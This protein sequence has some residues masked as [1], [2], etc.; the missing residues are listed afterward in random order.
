MGLARC[1]T[2][3][4]VSMEGGGVGGGCAGGGVP[5]G[6]VP[7]MFWCGEVSLEAKQMSLYMIL[8]VTTLYGV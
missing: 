7:A 4:P 1:G 3:F 2:V 5:L 6:A 8:P